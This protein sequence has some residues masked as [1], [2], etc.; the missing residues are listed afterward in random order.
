MALALATTTLATG[1]AG[2]GRGPGSDAVII[3]ALLDDG[4]VGTGT[5]LAI[6]G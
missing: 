4:L 6:G 2:D 3:E 5:D 1:V